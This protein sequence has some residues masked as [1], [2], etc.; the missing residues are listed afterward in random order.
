M[1]ALMETPAQ[2]P[3]PKHPDLPAIMTCARCGTFACASCRGTRDPS[4]CADCDARSAPASFEVGDILQASFQ[5]LGRVPRAAAALAGAQIVFGLLTFPLTRAMGAGQ[6]FVPGAMPDLSRLAPLLGA[7][8]ITSLIFTA[9]VYSIFIRFLG[10]IVENNPRPF[11]ETARAGLN[12]APAMLGL[13]IL[14]TLMLSFG[15]ACCLAPGIFF[16]TALIFAVPAVV[17]EP[18]GPIAAL[19]ISW[20]RTTGHRW[21][22]LVVLLLIFAILVGVGLVFFMLTLFLGRLGTP[23]QLVASVLQQG[24]SGLVVALMVTIMVVGFLHLSG[25]WRPLGE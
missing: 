22:I 25:R 3:C 24:V 10:D 21:Q 14:L 6:P 7:S 19:S 20:E 1:S 5:L 17:L 2:T 8:S 9:V 18:A 16:S 23:G 11:G 12:H 15:F 4:L 13:N